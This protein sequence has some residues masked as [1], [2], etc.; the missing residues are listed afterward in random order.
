MWVG[1]YGRWKEMLGHNEAFRT[2]PSFDARAHARKDEALLNCLLASYEKKY[3]SEFPNW[4]ERMRA[5]TTSG[6]RVLLQYVP[7]PA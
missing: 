2:G 6:E 3:P 5:G 7:A 4:R 1:N